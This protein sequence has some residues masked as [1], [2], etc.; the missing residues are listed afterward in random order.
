MQPPAAT[1]AASARQLWTL[2]ALGES[3]FEVRNVATGQSLAIDATGRLVALALAGNLLAPLSLRLKP[4]GICIA[5]TATTQCSNHDSPPEKDS[6]PEHDSPP[7]KD[8]QAHLHAGDLIHLLP[9]AG[10]RFT[11][12]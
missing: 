11:D 7:E 3:R 10:A 12:K 1:V 8:R 6:P 2:H 5:A 9:S 4:E